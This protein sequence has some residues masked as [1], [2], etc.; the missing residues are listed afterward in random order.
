MY[1][2]VCVCE[3]GGE[4][5]KDSSSCQKKQQKKEVKSKKFKETVSNNIKT[6]KQYVQCYY[7]QPQSTN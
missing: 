2:R 7:Y 4:K 1:L 5:E 6:T 3:G